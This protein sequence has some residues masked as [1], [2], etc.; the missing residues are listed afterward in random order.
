MT[1]E[2]SIR[3]VPLTMMRWTL[4][5]TGAGAVAAAGGGV[6][7]LGLAGALASAAEPASVSIRT[8]A[9][10]AR[11]TRANRVMWLIQSSLVLVMWLGRPVPAGPRGFRK[12]LGERGHSRSQGGKSPAPPPARA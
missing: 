11:V 10:T 12:D 9:G 4:C 6:A 5:V 7:G 2:G 3:W 8:N 1:V